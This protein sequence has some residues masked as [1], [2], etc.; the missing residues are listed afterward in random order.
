MM[1]GAAVGGALLAAPALKT[2][3]LAVCEGA[4]ELPGHFAASKLSETVYAY[5]SWRPGADSGTIRDQVAKVGLQTAIDH[6]KLFEIRADPND[7][8]HLDV[9]QKELIAARDRLG[10]ANVQADQE[11]WL[12]QLRVYNLLVAVSYLLQS[13]MG[14]DVEAGLKAVKIFLEPMFQ[15]FKEK[16]ISARAAAFNP[17]KKVAAIKKDYDEHIAIWVERLLHHHGA[18]W[19]GQL[20][21]HIETDQQ[22][23]MVVTIVMNIDSTPSDVVMPTGPCHQCQV[24]FLTDRGCSNPHCPTAPTDKCSGPL[25]LQIAGKG[26]FQNAFAEWG[27]GSLT[28]RLLARGGE[29]IAT[30]DCPPGQEIRTR[31]PKSK[32][33]GRPHCFRVDLPAADSDYNMKYIIDPESDLER[34]RWERALTSPVTV[35]PAAGGAGVALDFGAGVGGG[36]RAFGGGGGAQMIPV[37]GSGGGAPAHACASLMYAGGGAGAWEW[38]SDQGSWTAYPPSDNEK[39]EAAFSR[40]ERNVDISSTDGV[41]RYVDPCKKPHAVQCRWDD[42]L[43]KR[44]VRRVTTGGGAPQQPLVV[45]VPT[46]V[47]SGRIQKLQKQIPEKEATI[48]LLRAEGMPT[49]QVDCLVGELA[50]ARQ[51]LAWLQ[52]QAAAVAYPAYP[53]PVPAAGIIPREPDPEPAPEPQPHAAYGGPAVADVH[54]AAPSA[55]VVASAAALPPASPPGYYQA[56]LPPGWEERFDAAQKPWYINHN[57]KTTHW[58]P[59]DGYR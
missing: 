56:A 37:G 26:T 12:H 48:A 10:L 2:L 1:T 45:S 3:T 58:D 46:P 31:P 22:S 4:I 29:L 16:L 28:L 43:T 59:P 35:T 15:L 23:G 8:A 6:L 24:G 13:R 50:A 27:A 17:G 49:V 14:Q 52:Q 5:L 40:G 47:P 44:A 41:H 30:F 57:T 54:A 9:A 32:R 55:P 34:K 42:P 21:T 7:M 38:R 33:P 39:L 18:R 51:E 19:A 25:K 20:T 36:H 53:A 11:M